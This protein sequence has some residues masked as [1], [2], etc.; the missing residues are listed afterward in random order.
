[1]QCI[2]DNIMVIILYRIDT[3]DVTDHFPHPLFEES[4]EVINS[5]NTN[6]MRC[7]FADVK[8]RR[9][10]EHHVIEYSLGWNVIFWNED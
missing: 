10:I 3:F 9:M 6:S 2:F 8:R 7:S 5:C 4:Q 1:M